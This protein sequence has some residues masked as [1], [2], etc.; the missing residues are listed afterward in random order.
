M[1][2]AEAFLF[3][4]VAPVATG[5]AY[6]EENGFVFSFSFIQGF[7]APRVPVYWVVS[8]LEKIRAFFV[9]QPVWLFFLIWLQ[10]GVLPVTI[11]YCTRF[12]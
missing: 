8:V 10:K 3:H 1:L 2:V 11:I 7:L 5:V 6:A 4:D 9:N 12:Y